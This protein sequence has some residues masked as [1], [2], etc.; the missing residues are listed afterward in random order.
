MLTVSVAHIRP[1]V[2]VCP[3]LLEMRLAVVKHLHKICVIK[4]TSA[5]LIRHAF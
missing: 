2:N 1:S 5:R 3:V 4:T